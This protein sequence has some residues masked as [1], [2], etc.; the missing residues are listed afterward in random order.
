M[1]TKS[2][3]ER[4]DAIQ[5]GLDEIFSELNLIFSKLA[6]K[7]IDVHEAIRMQ[8]EA[9]SK[10]KTLEAEVKQLKKYVKNN[11]NQSK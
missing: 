11:A 5:D 8:K 2:I 9:E 4:F 7:E 10:R 1:E 3:K 6:S